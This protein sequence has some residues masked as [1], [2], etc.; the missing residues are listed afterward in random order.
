MPDQPETTACSRNQHIVGVKR[1]VLTSVSMDIN[2]EQTAAKGGFAESNFFSGLRPVCRTRQWSRRG[3][4]S[5]PNR[6]QGFPFK[7]YPTG[8]HSNILLSSLLGL[9]STMAYILSD[10]PKS[11]MIFYQVPLYANSDWIVTE[12]G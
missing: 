11:H 1:G 2:Y 6:G 4:V 8:D 7:G 10:S 5:S 9:E 12:A 3:T